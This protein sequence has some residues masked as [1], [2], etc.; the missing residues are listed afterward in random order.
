MEQNRR[1]DLTCW[2]TLADLGSHKSIQRTLYTI[3]SRNC[4]P[5]VNRRRFQFGMTKQFLDESNIGP[6]FDK[7]GCERVPQ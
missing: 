5:S 6:V 2:A 1:N 4:C 3:L 7:V